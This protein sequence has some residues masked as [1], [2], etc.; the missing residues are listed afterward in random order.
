LTSSRARARPSTYQIRARFPERETLERQDALMRF[1]G[2]L[3]PAAVEELADLLEEEYGL[4]FGFFRPSDR[5]YW[6]SEHLPLTRWWSWLWAEAALEDA[7]TTLS[8]ELG[9]RAGNAA[10]DART[11][12]LGELATAWCGAAS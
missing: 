9:K 4:P 5:V 7:L 2:G 11:A 6:L 10:I 1:W 3:P 12:T 8:Y